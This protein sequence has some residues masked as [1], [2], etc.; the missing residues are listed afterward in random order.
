[1]LQ[2]QCPH[3]Q[4]TRDEE[5]FTY[6]GPLERRRPQSPAE[7]T[8][9]EWSTY[10]FTRENKKGYTLERWR[11][12]YGCRQWFAIERHT[13]TH[14]IKRIFPLTALAS[15]ESADNDEPGEG[16]KVYEVA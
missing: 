11:H 6:G 3:C 9:E 15:D 16:E 10:M 4:G 13:E 7:L 8:D 5:E 2:I 14:L 1:M 12:T